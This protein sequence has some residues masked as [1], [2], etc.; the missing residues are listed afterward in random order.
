[1]VDIGIQGGKFCVVQKTW[2]RV[3]PHQLCLRRPVVAEGEEQDGENVSGAQR[4]EENV[5]KK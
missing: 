4:A 3:P 1:M 5:V 2:S